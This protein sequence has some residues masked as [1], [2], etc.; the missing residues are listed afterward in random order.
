MSAP[1]ASG[2]CPRGDANV[3]STTTSGRSPRAPPWPRA[4][5]AIARCP[6]PSATGS[7]ASRAR[8]SG[9]VRSSLRSGARAPN[10][11]RPRG[12]RSERRCR[13]HAGPARRG[14]T[15]PHRRRPRRRPPRRVAGARRWPRSWRSRSRTPPRAPLPR[16]ERPPPRGGSGSGCRSGRTPSRRAAAPTPSCAN[17][18]VW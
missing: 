12:P 14:G 13:G 11:R 18:L 7:T 17:V 1:S 8:P 15:C 16:A 10:R 4:R 5:R 9:F 6:R 3:L 2:C